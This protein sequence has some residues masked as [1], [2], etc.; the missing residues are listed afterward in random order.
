MSATA[1]GEANDAKI[2][3][4]LAGA[5][6]ESD[7][8]SRLAYEAQQAYEGALAKVEKQKA[9]VAEAEASVKALKKVADQARKAAEK[10]GA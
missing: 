7:K 8:L 6:E 1:R 10:A 5:F 2:N 9:H 4:S 3:S